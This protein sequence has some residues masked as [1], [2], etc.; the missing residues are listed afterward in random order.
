MTR[1]IKDQFLLFSGIYLL[2]L[3][4][5]VA[6]A[7]S[8]VENN[9]PVVQII[10]PRA[11]EQLKWNSLVPYS[12]NVNDVED[13]N[14]AYDEIANLEIIL[15]IKYLEDSSLTTKY[16][17]HIDQDLETLFTMSKKTCLICHA[18]T[19]KLIGPS[20]DLIA[21]RYKGVENAKTYLVEKVIKGG[22]GTWGE[23]QMPTNPDLNKKEAG[24][25]IDWILKQGDNPT[26]F[27]VGDAGAIR[28]QEMQKRSDKSV[29]IITA[30]Y[31]D[32]G[33]SDDPDN[34]KHSS[35][36]IKLKLKQ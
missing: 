17:N 15:L 1:F 32:H 16:L 12:I 21:K 25:L 20:F 30:G 33:L 26:L 2:S 14:S 28:T 22:T 13:G 35:H 27:Y 23:V 8:K 34:R 11:N 3:I 5:F 9:A 10:K 29:Y 36:S 19:T 24:Q 4:S 18:A 6:H 7:Q 31:Q